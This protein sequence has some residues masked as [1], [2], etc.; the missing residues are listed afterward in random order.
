MMAHLGE[1]GRQR[2]LSPTSHSLGFRDS[3]ALD[4]REQARSAAR[5]V[6]TLQSGERG[7]PRWLTYQRAAVRLAELA[8]SRP[9]N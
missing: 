1:R 5:L 6:W 8:E 7:R 2:G 3:A 9:A 4:R